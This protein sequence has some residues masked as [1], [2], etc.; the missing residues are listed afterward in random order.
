MFQI[1]HN[2]YS[3]YKILL[4]VSPQQH[5][6]ITAINDILNIWLFWLV[7]SQT[8][9]WNFETSVVENL[10]HYT[11]SVFINSSAVFSVF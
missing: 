5:G 9:F 3:S 11:V 8:L 1:M 10:Y 4:A 6:E 7:K 2:T